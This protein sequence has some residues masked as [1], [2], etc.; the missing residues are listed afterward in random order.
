MGERDRQHNQNS[1]SN[2]CNRRNFRSN[3][4]SFIFVP[5]AECTKLSST[6]RLDAEER[7]F[8]GARLDV[9]NFRLHS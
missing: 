1:C 2:Y 5:L 6:V 9:L 8:S 7:A 4:I 3:L